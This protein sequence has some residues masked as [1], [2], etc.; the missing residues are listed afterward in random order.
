[1]AR[2][3]PGSDGS[4]S[5]PSPLRVAAE[6]AYDAV[7]WFVGRIY[8]AVNSLRSP[9]ARESLL[10]GIAYLTGVAGLTMSVLGDP[11]DPSGTYGVAGIGLMGLSFACLFVVSVSILRAT[12]GRVGGD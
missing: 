4:G 7:Y 3:P 5:D 2:S 8:A 12:G 9:A 10:I 1:M 11:A 6:W